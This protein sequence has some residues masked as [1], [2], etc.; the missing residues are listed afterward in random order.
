MATGLRPRGRGSD[1]LVEAARKGGALLERAYRQ[2][3]NNQLRTG[4][5]KGNPTV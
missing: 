3:M 1:A 2:A 5:D 4:T